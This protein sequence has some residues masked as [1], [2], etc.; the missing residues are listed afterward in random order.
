MPIPGFD[1]EEHE[2]P[3]EDAPILEDKDDESLRLRIQVM[4]LLKR[5]YKTRD[6]KISLR[7]RKG[8]KRNRGIRRM[9]ATSS[10]SRRTSRLR[11]TGWLYQ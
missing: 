7:K 3:P 4:E 10:Q 8:K 1:R 5:S 6:E 2:E 9:K 11:S